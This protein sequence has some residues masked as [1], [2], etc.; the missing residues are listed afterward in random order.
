[1]YPNQLKCHF[2]TNLQTYKRIIS[3]KKCGSWEISLPSMPTSKLYINCNFFIKRDLRPPGNNDK[4]EGRKRITTPKHY[5]SFKEIE[6]S[7]VKM[8]QL[9]TLHPLHLAPNHFYPSYNLKNSN[10]ISFLPNKFWKENPRSKTHTFRFA[11][12]N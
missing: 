6:D 9:S 12:T 3:R 11:W 5:W 7:E 10:R 8:L 2:T 4:Q 1:M